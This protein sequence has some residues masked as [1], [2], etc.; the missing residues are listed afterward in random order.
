ME[1]TLDTTSRH[2]LRW[3]GI[4]GF[5][6]II[7]G[8]FGAH[9][10]PKDMSPEN[11]VTFETGVRYHLAHALALLACA[12]VFRA[13]VPARIAFWGFNLGIVFF[14]VAL[15]VLALTD[16]KKLGMVAPIG[17]LLLLAGWIAMV[18]EANREP[19]RSDSN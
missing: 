12:R 5:L 4:M 11:V 3:A 9:C 16:I 19:S 14:S 17:G 10:L 1:P 18:L 8:T 13:G 2:F 6:A 7:M 15:Y